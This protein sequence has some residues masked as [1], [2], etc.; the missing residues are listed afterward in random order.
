MASRWHQVTAGPP[1]KNQC[2]PFHHERPQRDDAQWKKVEKMER[3]YLLSQ[4]NLLKNKSAPFSP[5]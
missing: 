5:Y 1:Q 2:R 3:I 4:P